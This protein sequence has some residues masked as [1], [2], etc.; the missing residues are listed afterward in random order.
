MEIHNPR[1]TGSLNISGSLVING[2]S[3]NTATSGTSGASGAT[4]TSGSSGSSGSSGTMG[5]A[6]SGGTSGSSGTMGT[7]GSGGTSGTSVSVSGTANTVVK[8]ASSTT[9]GNSN[10]TDDGTN[11]RLNGNTTVTGSV[12]ITG[13]LTAQQ[14]IVSSSVTHLTTSFS[15]GSTKF[16]DSIDDTHQFTGS[17][18]VTGSQTINGTLGVSIGGS[19]ELSVQQTSVIL[20]NIVTDAHRVTGSFNVSGSLATTGT[21]TF[22]GLIN[23]NSQTVAANGSINVESLDPAIRFRVTSGT[24]NSRIYEWRAV[25]AGTVND[26]MQLRLWND[27]QSSA[28]TLFSVSPTGAG[29]FTSSVTA[30]S[31]IRSGGTSSQFLKADGSVDSSTYLTSA[32]VLSTVLTPYS[33]GANSAVT[34]SDTIE[35]AIEKL[36]GQVNARL[37]SYT[38]TSTLANV[39]ARGATTNSSITVN[40]Y[41]TV[42]GATSSSS[43]YMSDSDEGQ[44]E[45][46]CN[47]NRIGFLTQA[48]GWGSYCNDDGSWVSVSDITAYS[49]VRVKENINTITNALSKVTA[50]RGVS[51]NRIDDSNKI[52][53]IG[54]IAQEVQEVVSELVQ[55]QNDGMLSVSYGNMSGLF[56]EAFKEMDDKINAQANEIAELKELVKQLINK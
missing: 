7:A 1:I 14:Y 12:V 48:G 8:F 39:T 35:T 46:H 21:S 11:I 15:S 37:S 30:S 25:A 34:T 55:E 41:L 22:S 19:T 27:A 28:T 53:K 47:S 2:A 18:N 29:I 4:G 45:L 56:I 31:I 36:Q 32:T 24:A 23:A 10:I 6:G 33:V 38:E 51:Y 42:V 16:G 9:V 44:R 52:T 26:I 5:T 20:G 40:G 54:V 3:Y 43:I 13:N 49:D 50:L 17:L